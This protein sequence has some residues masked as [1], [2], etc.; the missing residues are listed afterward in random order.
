[1]NRRAA[2]LLAFVVLLGGPAYAQP[3]QVERGMPH[4]PV[5]VVAVEADPGQLNP[6]ISTASPVHRVADSLFNGLVSVAADGSI[7]PDLAEGWSASDG[8]NGPETV[9]RFTL[10][11]GIRWHDGVAFS[12]EDVAFTLQEVLFKHHARAR[13]GLAPAVEAVEA[14][15]ARTVIIRLKRPH[16]ALLAQLDVT[17]AAILP[18]HLYEGTDPLTNPYNMR[19]VGTG[20]YRFV[21][22]E[23]GRQ[24][25]FARNDTYF[26]M[27][28]PAVGR[29][30]FRVIPEAADQVA[31][32]RSGEVDYLPRVSAEDARLLA[33]DAGPD[34][35][36][37]LRHVHGGPGGSN[38]QMV[39]AFNLDRPALSSLALRRAVAMGIDRQEL[40]DDLVPGQGRVARAPLSAGLADF[41]NAAQVTLPPHDPAA[42]KAAIAA[43]APPPMVLL[44]FTNFAPW[45][46]AIRADLAPLGLTVETRTMA[47]RDFEAAVFQ[48][49]DFD[50]ALISYCQGPDPAVGAAR[51]YSSQSIGLP[52]GNAAGWRDATVDEALDD[53]VGRRHHRILAWASIQDKAA[54]ALPYVW[55]ADTDFTV[56]WRRELMGFSPWSGQFAE[57]VS[58]RR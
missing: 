1:M 24:T 29:L 53:A 10:R 13:A 12:A 40:V 54:A 20:P 41:A 43:V 38:C 28:Q 34:G 15:D 22:Y 50:M 4:E 27:R 5:V 23:A 33:A 30:V 51:M 8:P 3:W 7:R 57:S 49:R 17:E 18:R 58:P 31:A 46:E 11:D 56:A 2:L 36:L 47:P 48:R 6:A 44:S 21:S 16:P 55:L 25:V 14:P 42:A 32:L 45:A 39:L 9:W 37:V 35:P 19:P 26:K 52:F